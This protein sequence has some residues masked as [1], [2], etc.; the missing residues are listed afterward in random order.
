MLG[1]VLKLSVLKFFFFFFFFNTDLNFSFF[2]KFLA[3][4]GLCCCVQAFSSFG[5]LGLLSSCGVG[6]SHCSG[7]SLQ[8]R[9]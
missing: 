5:E 2:K 9:F 6:A 1:K 8:S 3:A 4:L 7:F